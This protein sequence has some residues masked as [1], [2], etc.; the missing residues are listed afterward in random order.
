M[1]D[2]SAFFYY[3]KNYKD[4]IN[5]N[6]KTDDLINEMLSSFVIAKNKLCYIREYI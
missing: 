1:R 2:I 5:D 4:T 6:G 3:I